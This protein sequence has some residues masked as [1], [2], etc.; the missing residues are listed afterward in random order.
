MDSRMRRTP[1]GVTQDDMLKW[2]L[3][4]AWCEG[5][6][7]PERRGLMFQGIG[8]FAKSVCQRFCF[9]SLFLPVR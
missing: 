6:E 8:K 4:V 7:W 3:D 9:C 2:C 1:P 5:L